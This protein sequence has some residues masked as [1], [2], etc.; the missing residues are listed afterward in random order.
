M[1]TNSFNLFSFVMFCFFMPFSISNAQQKTTTS[2]ALNQDVKKLDVLR[3]FIPSGWFD[4]GEDP[5]RRYLQFDPA[6]KEKPHSEPIC[7][8]ITYTPGP[9]GSA[10]IYWQNKPDNWGMAPGNDYSKRGFTKLTFWA[11]GDEGGELIQFI[12]G[13]IQEKGMPFKDSYESTSGFIPLG[14]EWK[15]Y[16]IDLTRM[17]LKS[18]IGGFCFSAPASSSTIVFFID[19]VYFE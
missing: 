16:T 1:K 15:Q 6:C 17:S 18:V 3:Y 11:K 14:K 8:K 12:S 13:G 9:E 7:A 5:E 4:D 2:F 10:G 19:D